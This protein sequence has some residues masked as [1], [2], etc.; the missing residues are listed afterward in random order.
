MLAKSSNFDQKLEMLVK[1]ITV[2]TENRNLVQKSQ[3]RAEA[4]ILWKVGNVGLRSKFLSEVLAKVPSVK[5]GF[6]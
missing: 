2:Y 6:L 5:N 1:K 4:E 3:I